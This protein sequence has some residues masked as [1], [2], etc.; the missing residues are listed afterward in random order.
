MEFSWYHQMSNKEIETI[1]RHEDGVALVTHKLIEGEWYC[2][3]KTK[4]VLGLT[5]YIMMNGKE[6]PSNEQIEEIAKRFAFELLRQGAI[7][8][9]TYR[10]PTEDKVR[11]QYRMVAVKGLEK[12]L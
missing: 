10:M 6:T 9:E 4:D 3:F 11:Y 7:K 5:D 12:Y 8:L 1:I 2:T